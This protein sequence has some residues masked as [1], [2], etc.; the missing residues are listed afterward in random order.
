[1]MGM[2]SRTDTHEFLSMKAVNA[3]TMNTVA[4]RIENPRRL[5]SYSWRTMLP[6]L[7]KRLGFSAAERQAIGEYGTLKNTS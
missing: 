3:I 1:M 7:A 2:I 4:E 5:A 6:T